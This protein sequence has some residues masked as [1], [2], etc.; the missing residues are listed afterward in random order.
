MPTT[1]V[2]TFTAMPAADGIVYIQA[3]QEDGSKRALPALLGFELK[4]ETSFDTAWQLAQDMQNHITGI[5]MKVAR[6]CR[7]PNYR[8]NDAELSPTNKAHAATIRAQVCFLN[9]PFPSSS[10][11]MLLTMRRASSNVRNVTVRI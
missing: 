4:S 7:D 1:I 3:L 2:V 9:L 11:A 8:R 6:P 10:F 5:K